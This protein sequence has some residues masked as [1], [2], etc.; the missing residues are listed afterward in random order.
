MGAGITA[1]GTLHLDEAKLREALREDPEAVAAL[2]TGEEGMAG[3][4][5]AYLKEAL[6]R[7][8][9]GGLFTAKDEAIC[10]PDKGFAETDGADGGAAGAAGGATEAAV[11]AVGE[12]VG[13]A[14]EP[15]QLAGAAA[16]RLYRQ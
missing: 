2:F 3:R 13:S 5:D 14:A 11:C 6:T 4:L 1:D 7:D 15:K 12:G 16:G 8:K 9:T 10:Q